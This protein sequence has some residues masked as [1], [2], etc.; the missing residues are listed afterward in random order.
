MTK[1]YKSILFAC[2]TFLLGLLMY[3]L[4]HDT[5]AIEAGRLLPLVLLYLIGLLAGLLLKP[6]IE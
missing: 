2:G 1:L 6:A 5:A 3:C 4:R